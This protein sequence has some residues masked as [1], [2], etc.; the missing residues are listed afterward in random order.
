MI[1]AVN[2]QCLKETMKI[3][4]LERTGST[5]VPP[6]MGPNTG[7]GSWCQ[8]GWSCWSA[9]APGAHEPLPSSA[10]ALRSQ[11][12]FPLCHHFLTTPTLYSWG[13]VPFSRHPLLFW[14]GKFWLHSVL[15]SA[16]R[17][18]Y[19]LKNRCDRENE[20]FNFLP[21]QNHMKRKYQEK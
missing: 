2:F 19:T 12:D 17:E 18:E 11:P 5:V 13:Y 20:V 3:E 16:V 10:G 4:E 9:N 15:V 1:K 6:G 21:L 8:G 7:T 14:Q